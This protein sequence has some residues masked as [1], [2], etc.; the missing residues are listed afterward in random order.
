M[1]RG[2]YTS[3]YGDKL[4]KVYKFRK[5]DYDLF[6]NDVPETTRG[7]VDLYSESD[8]ISQGHVVL[9]YDIECEME[10]GCRPSR[11]TRTN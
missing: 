9:T 6:E 3:I 7:L 4:T 11:S 5:D 10:S 8:E 1:K 2:E